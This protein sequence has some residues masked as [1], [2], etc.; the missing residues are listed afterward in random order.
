MLRNGQLH[1]PDQ[2][3]CFQC[4]SEEEYGLRV[5]KQLSAQQQEQLA[6]VER[7]AEQQGGFPGA[8]IVQMATI[9]LP[10]VCS[11]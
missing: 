5:R 10:G 2:F 1:S 6:A 9:T 7:R 8:E 4:V 11:A 3:V